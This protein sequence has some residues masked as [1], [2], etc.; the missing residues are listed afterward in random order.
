MTKYYIL[1]ISTHYCQLNTY[2][3]YVFN[4]GSD[5]IYYNLNTE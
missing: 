4:V 3:V 5:D 1:V 2:I